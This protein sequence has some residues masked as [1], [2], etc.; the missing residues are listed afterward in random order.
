MKRCNNCD[1]ENE[2]EAKF[3]LSCGT[4]LTASKS[5]KSSVPTQLRNSTTNTISRIK[6]YAT[7]IKWLFFISAFVMFI[8]AVSSG[9]GYIMLSAIV[10]IIFMIIAA[11]I[12]EAFILWYALTLEHLSQINEKIN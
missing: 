12:T 10:F 2:N 8:A 7:I 3:C 5:K 1:F 4:K 11:L 6:S 9:E